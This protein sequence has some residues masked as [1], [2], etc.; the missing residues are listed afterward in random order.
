MDVKKCNRL[1]VGFLNLKRRKKSPLLS[2][3][4]I[5]K[6]RRVL[7]MVFRV[8]HSAAKVLPV[9]ALAPCLIDRPYRIRE[10]REVR[11]AHRRHVCRPLRVVL[12][13]RVE[14]EPPPTPNMC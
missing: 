2:A 9:K 7:R 4:K 14:V 5:C 6:R 11:R 8:E 12:L 13:V 10:V 3:G 1:L